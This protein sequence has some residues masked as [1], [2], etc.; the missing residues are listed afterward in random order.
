MIRLPST[1]R[2]YFCKLSS[3]VQASGIANTS[4]YG[5]R[6]EDRQLSHKRKVCRPVSHS[7]MNLSQI[8]CPDT[9]SFHSLTCPLCYLGGQ[10]G[11]HATQPAVDLC[12]PS[13]KVPSPW[14]PSV[15]AINGKALIYAMRFLQLEHGGFSVTG[16]KGAQSR[17]ALNGR[18]CQI[19]SNQIAIFKT[20]EKCRHNAQGSY[21]V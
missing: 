13:G 16:I 10:G 19:R 12:R 15:S 7:R 20:V 21:N 18:R 6:S 3:S 4:T 9:I 8:L 1:W 5:V 14:K 11:Q 2:R 17:E